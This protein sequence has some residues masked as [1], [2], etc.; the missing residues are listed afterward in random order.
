MG[1]FSR[2]PKYKK[3]KDSWRRPRGRHNKLRK[4]K[5]SKGKKPSPGYGSSERGK[6]PSGYYEKLIHNPQALKDVEKERE[7]VRIAK[8]V[9]KKKKKII[10]E[11]AKKMGL[12][13]F[14]PYKEED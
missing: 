7:G 13:I 2:H 9:G 3:L 12:K 14:N 1:K 10:T 11:K 5:K 8:G 4:S 6:H